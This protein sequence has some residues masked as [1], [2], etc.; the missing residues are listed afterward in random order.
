MLAPGRAGAFL[1]R[2]GCHCLVKSRRPTPFPPLEIPVN[3]LRTQLSGCG[4]HV[5][6]VRWVSGL[7]QRSDDRASH[8]VR[9]PPR[10]RARSEDWPLIVYNH[11][12]GRATELLKIPVSILIQYVTYRYTGRGG[13]SI[14]RE[15]VTYPH[16]QPPVPTA[17]F[18]QLSL[19]PHTPSL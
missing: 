16:N 10:R 18:V 17:Y 1:T 13:K 12:E 5:K 6:H 2:P 11:G 7:G 9:Q 15:C 8:R 14:Y 19:H 4:Q 3:F